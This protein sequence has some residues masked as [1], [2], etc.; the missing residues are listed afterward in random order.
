MFVFSVPNKSDV[1]SF[2][3]KTSCKVSFEMDPQTFLLSQIP[4]EEAISWAPV[5]QLGGWCRRRSA[6][7]ASMKTPEAH[8]FGK[9]E[10]VG[11]A[12]EVKMDTDALLK[13]IEEYNR[14]RPLD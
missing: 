13:D 3:P 10:P 2:S 12:G 4:A 8:C 11:I 14:Q 6:W 7:T 9:E 5:N 1:F